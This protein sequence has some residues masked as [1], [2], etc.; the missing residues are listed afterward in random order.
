MELLPILFVLGGVTVLGLITALVV[1][2]RKA[3]RRIADHVRDILQRG[4]T[5]LGASVRQTDAVSDAAGRWVRGVMNV[6]IGAA[7]YGTSC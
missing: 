6:G 4:S 1:A 3:D 2:V 5:P 7:R